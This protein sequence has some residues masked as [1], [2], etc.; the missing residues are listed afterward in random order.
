[1]IASVAL[2]LPEQASAAL[3]RRLAEL[4]EEF[5]ERLNFR[6][7]GPLPASSFATVEVTLPSFEVV[8]EARRALNLGASAKLADIKSAYRQLIRQSHP[9]VSAATSV[10]GKQAAQI[11]NAYK[12]LMSYAEALPLPG[13]E[14]ALADAG[15]RFDRGAVESAIIVAV[16]RQELPPS[17]AEVQL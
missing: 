17:R 11:T 8:D 15:C 6:C 16:R 3:D 2:L 13:R 1:M 5:D 10:D 4:D 14:S 12:T 7:V 9:D